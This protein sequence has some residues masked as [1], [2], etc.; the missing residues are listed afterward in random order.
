MSPHPP[1]IVC[2]KR[3]EGNECLDET[4]ARHFGLNAGDERTCHV[5]KYKQG[6]EAPTV[7]PCITWEKGPLLSR[8][9]PLTVSTLYEVFQCNSIK[10]TQ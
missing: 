6:V 1:F 5:C 10:T 2:R 7:C 4:S 8:A 3:A 9:K